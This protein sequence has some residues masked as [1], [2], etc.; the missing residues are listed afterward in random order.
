MLHWFLIYALSY[1]QKN[2]STT[3][4]QVPPRSPHG[5]HSQQNNT[6]YTNTSNTNYHTTTASGGGAIPNPVQRVRSL[7]MDTDSEVSCIYGPILEVCAFFCMWLMC[8]NSV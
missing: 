4:P 2:A 8:N 5:R 6:N 3:L 7:G 1:T